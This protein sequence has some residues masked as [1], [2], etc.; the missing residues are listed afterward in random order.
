[1]YFGYTTLAVAIGTLLDLIIGDPHNIWHPVMGIGKLVRVL[2]NKIR[3]QADGSESKLKVGG[4]LLWFLVIAVSSAISGGILFIAWKISPFLYLAI[5]SV[6]SCQIM[7][8]KCLRDESMKVYYSLEE[9]DIEKARENVSMIVGRDTDRLSK[10]GIIKATVETVAENTSDGSIVPLFYLM[11]GGPVLGFLYKAVNTMDSMIGYKNEKYIHIGWMAAKMDDL[12]N[13]IPARLTAAAMIASSGIL[14]LDMKN[15]I[16]IFK[17]DRYKSPSPNSAQSE[18]VVAGA[19]GIRLLGDAYYFGELHHKEYIGD[20]INKIETGNIV[21][22]N[23]IL[24][25]T[26]IVSFIMFIS[27]RIAVGAICL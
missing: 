13:Y 24:Y 11:I 4:I 9:N 1:M 2:E 23:N 12:F 5:A 27:I 16:H 3:K 19:L 25:V 26:L 17:R 18:S 8:T 10:E 20:E 7:A 15:A 21:S 14:G 6:M 22:A